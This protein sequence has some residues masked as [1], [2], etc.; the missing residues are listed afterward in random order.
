MIAVCKE[1]WG[2]QVGMAEIS[3]RYTISRRVVERDAPGVGTC[4]VAGT[5]LHG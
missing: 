4:C 2:L 1:K 3:D 5:S